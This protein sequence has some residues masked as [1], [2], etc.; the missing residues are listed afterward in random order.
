PRSPLAPYTTLFRSHPS[1]G[2]DAGGA[3][4]PCVAGGGRQ[5]VHHDELGLLHPLDHQ[6][7][8]S[9]TSFDG[10]VLG[11]VEVDQQDLELVSVTAVDEA[12][13]VEAGDA[14]LESQAAA[15]LYEPGS[16]PRQGEGDAGW[17]QRSAAT[18]REGD[19][20]TGHQVGPG[21]A[22]VGVGGQAEVRV[23]ATDRYV[24]HG[25]TVDGG[26]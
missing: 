26:R 11:R 17:Y 3:E 22:H 16:A 1:V 15:G 21:I 5:L 18:G 4:A 7:G 10:E 9:I 25:P 6:L 14:V 23:E 19:R 12:R 8:D 20:L 24:Q 13:G 2:A